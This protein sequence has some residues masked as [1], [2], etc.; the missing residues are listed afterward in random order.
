MSMVFDTTIPGERIRGVVAAAAAVRRGEV[1]VLPTET[2]YGV[3][4]DA[5]HPLGV[6]RLLEAKAR[7]RDLPLPVLV[8][9]PSTVEGLAYEL[10]WSTRLLI[11][12][13]WPG[14]LTLVV[15]HQPSLA[16]DVGDPQGHVALRMPLHPVALEVLVETGPM[17]VTTA[18]RAGAP[19]PR[20]YGEAE[21]QL[22][23]A[24]SIYLDAGECA[25][26]PPSTIVDMTSRTPVLLRA[27][28][29]DLADLRTVCPDMVE[30][31][32]G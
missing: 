30:T 15:R 31:D 9:S 7:G 29:F 24:V 20:T 21:D 14:P 27:G 22:G 16:W 26:G 6:S 10:S 17:A 5:F 32:A 25:E 1:V 18:N 13:F 19:A 4:C 28:A 8:G 12:A 2:V 11:E 3:G 23:E